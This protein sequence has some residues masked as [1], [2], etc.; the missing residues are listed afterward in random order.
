MF[1]SEEVQFFLCADLLLCKGHVIEFLFTVV[2][3]LE[4]MHSPKPPHGFACTENH[5]HHKLKSME[6]KKMHDVKFSLTISGTKNH[7]TLIFLFLVLFLYLIAI[8]IW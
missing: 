7:N 8:F 4:S 2:V 5:P 1:K 3:T 6:D